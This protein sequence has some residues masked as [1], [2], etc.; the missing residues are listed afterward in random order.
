MTT[1]ASIRML[2]KTLDLI[3]PQNLFKAVTEITELRKMSKMRRKTWVIRC[4]RWY[5][6]LP[7]DKESGHT[8][9]RTE[10][11]TEARPGGIG[12]SDHFFM[13]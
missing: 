7:K 9:G 10:K 12:G 1:E 13:V 8:Q 11:E 4:L 2:L 6:I 3:K 5:K